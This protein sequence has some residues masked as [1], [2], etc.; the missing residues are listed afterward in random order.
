MP[1]LKRS[2]T[3]NPAQPVEVAP[4]Q[5]ERIVPVGRIVI[6]PAAE[7]LLNAQTVYQ[8]VQRHT[9]GDW[10]DVS[11][12]DRQGNEDALKND[13]DG[14]MSVYNL[15]QGTVWIITDYGRKVSTVLTP[16]DY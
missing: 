8:L 10:G 6:T 5:P 9:R 16:G 13:H 15:P 2:I 7:E 14:Y 12:D 3:I 1:P 11:D 4:I